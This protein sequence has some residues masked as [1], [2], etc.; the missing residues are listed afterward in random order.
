M[1]ERV[2]GSRRR[3]ERRPVLAGGILISSGE[4][5]N[6]F[7][8][9]FIS[10]RISVT[11]KWRSRRLY[12]FALRRPIL[13]PPAFFYCASS[14]RGKH[15]RKSFPIISNSS[16]TLSAL[17]KMGK[18]A[19]YRPKAASSSSG[20]LSGFMPARTANYTPRKKTQTL[21]VTM[22][23]PHR[24]E[25]KTR[26]ETLRKRKIRGGELL[27]GLVKRERRAPV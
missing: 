16:F 1:A 9:T 4:L 25:Q 12:Y 10:R 11:A 15:N 27:R 6:S 17:S 7:I 26:A 8:Q 22:K 21:Y 23:L 13:G 14:F 24:G 18:P 2:H 5:A 19:V 20:D 3:E